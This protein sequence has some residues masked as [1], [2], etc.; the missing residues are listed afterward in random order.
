[1][2]CLRHAYSHHLFFM[3]SETN[4]VTVEWTFINHC[5]IFFF[6]FLW[7]NDLLC[8]KIFV[9]SVMLVLF[10]VLTLVLYDPSSRTILNTF[11]ADMKIRFF[12]DGQIFKKCYLVIELKI[13]FYYLYEFVVMFI[14]GFVYFKYLLYDIAW[15]AVHNAIIA[16][17]AKCNI[18]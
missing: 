9:I 7:L 2:L 18:A 6:Y 5:F 14:I 13:S 8:L 10:I 11:I 15:L 3:S 12:V 1:M 16:R 4:S 17:M